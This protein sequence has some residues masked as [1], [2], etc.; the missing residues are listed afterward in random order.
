MQPYGWELAGQRDPG[1]VIP[2]NYLEPAL[3]PNFSRFFQ[4]QP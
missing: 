1:K 2:I 4:D 3:T